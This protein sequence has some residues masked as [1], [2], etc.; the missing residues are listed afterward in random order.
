[1]ENKRSRQSNVKASKFL[2]VISKI[3]EM[4]EK[5]EVRKCK[6]HHFKF[7]S[8][9]DGTMQKSIE[10][11]NSL[12]SHVQVESDQNRVAVR[13]PHV[14]SQLVQEI[15]RIVVVDSCRQPKRQTAR[16]SEA[17]ERT[18]LAR[19]QRPVRLLLRS[20]VPVSRTVDP[21]KLVLQP[22]IPKWAAVQKREFQVLQ[23]GKEFF[24]SWKRNEPC[25]VHTDGAQNSV[26]E[27]IPKITDVVIISKWGKSSADQ[28]HEPTEQRV[29]SEITENSPI[30]GNKIDTLHCEVEKEVL[31]AFKRKNVPSRCLQN[32]KA[33]KYFEAAVRLSE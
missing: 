2:N 13:V 11:K 20:N 31:T 22:S 33:E 17:N 3:Y 29:W 32:R 24:Y 21:R 8:K 9:F 23:K 5:W 30:T 16:V 18:A 15:L 4:W 14:P 6:K 19:T 25:P 28:N 10:F 1:M 26:C 27:P 12:R 7:Q